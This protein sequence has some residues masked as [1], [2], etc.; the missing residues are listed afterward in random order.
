MDGSRCTGHP[1]SVDLSLLARDLPAFRAHVG[2]R[3]NLWSNH[4]GTLRPFNGGARRTQ[5]GLG[6]WTDGGGVR[7]LRPEVTLLYKAALHRPKDDRDLD[8]TWSLLDAGA[9]EWLREAVGRLYPDHP[10][11]ERLG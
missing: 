2:D 10:W 8:V 3:W 5:S 11:R 9:Q 1:R 6:T 4:G 7:Y